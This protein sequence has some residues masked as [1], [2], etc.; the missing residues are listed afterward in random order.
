MRELIPAVGLVLA[1]VVVAWQQPG[2]APRE[3]AAP[4]PTRDVPAATP[5][6]SGRVPVTSGAPRSVRVPA[7]GVDARVDP[8]STRGTE[9]DPPADPARVG[10]WAQGARP[11]SPRGAVV[12]TGHTVHGGGG[13]FDDLET[14]AP[15]DVV[16]VRGAS[17]VTKYA[18]ESVE[19]MS[20]AE[21]A[22]RSPA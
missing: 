13:V 4:S 18:V 8:V 14:L 19:V 15:G 7:L 21:L 17:G 12:L 5:V 1:G 11:G 10:W 3:S 22:E 16:T 6:S 2:A 9:L 20:R